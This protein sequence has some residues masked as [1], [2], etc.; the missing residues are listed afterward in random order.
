MQQPGTREMTTTNRFE[1]LDGWRGVCACL[2]VLF[3]FHGHSPIYTT[4]LVR[5]SYL[6]VDFFFVLSGFV[7]AWNYANRLGDWPGVKRFLVLRLGRVYPLHLFMLLCFVAYESLRLLTNPDAFT[8]GNS[9]TAVVTNLLLLQSMDLHDSLTWNGPSWSISTEW[10]TYV[11]FALVCAWLGLR[12]G[13]IVA[14]A[15]VAPLLLLH[16]SKTGMDTTFDWGF[17]RCLFGFALGVACYRLYT[18]G[19]P[20]RPMGHMAVMTLTEFATVAAVVLFVSSAGTSPLSFM[21][22]F[23]FAIAVLVFAAEGGL[24]SRLF[25]SRPL[26]WLGT[27]SYSIYLTH[28]FVVLILPSVIKRIAHVDLWTAMALPNGQWV[29]AYGRNDIEGTLGYAGALALTLAFSACTY[30]WVEVP[31]RE[32]TRKWLSR[33]PRTAQAHAVHS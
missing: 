16:L 14:T 23:V 29:A 24:V 2:V 17:I 11:T 1:A 28:F 25:H 6:F 30:R 31:G 12:N 33:P 5:N 22:P 26:K 27:V 9:P 3:H 8:G 13:L 32:W 4:A 21:A 15:I 7:I 10:W 18:A 19:P 20:R